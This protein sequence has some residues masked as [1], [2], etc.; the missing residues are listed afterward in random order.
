MD[1]SDWRYWLFGAAGAA[2]TW[3]CPRI[4]RKLKGK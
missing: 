1:W 2:L 3:A 4:L